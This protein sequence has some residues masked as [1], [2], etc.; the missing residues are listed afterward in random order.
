MVVLIH[1]A[2]NNKLKRHIIRESWGGSHINK[3]GDIR[4]AFLL[5]QPSTPD[6]QEL[7]LQEHLAHR[8]IVQGSFIDSYRNLT[9]KHIMG[10]L[11]ATTFCPQVNNVYCNLKLLP[12]IISL[13]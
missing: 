5:A 4:I 9:Y 10:L 7:I 8:D 3:R 12:E 11:W 2:V 13:R 6:Q 1:S